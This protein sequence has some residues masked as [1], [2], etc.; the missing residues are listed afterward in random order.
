ME[1]DAGADGLKLFPADTLG[2]AVLK[3][4][5]AVLS[6]GVLVAVVGGVTPEAMPKA[7]KPAPTYMLA[8]SGAALSGTRG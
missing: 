8:H 7:L 2:P 3:A 1:T 4:H 6:E 5:R